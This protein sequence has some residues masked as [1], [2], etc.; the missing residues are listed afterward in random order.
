MKSINLI[1]AIL[2]VVFSACA[3]KTAST[4]LG[5]NPAKSSRGTPSTQGLRSNVRGA[6]SPAGASSVT[7]SASRQTDDDELASGGGTTTSGVRKKPSATNGAA[8]DSLAPG[9]AARQMGGGNASSVT[10][11]ASGSRNKSTA[12]NG[13][14]GDSSAPGGAA[15]Q[16]GVGNA[17]SVTGS[18][19]GSRNKSTATNGVAGD[20]SLRSGAANPSRDDRGVSSQEVGSGKAPAASASS[21]RS[22][23]GS[24]S[25][26]DGAQKIT[27]KFGANGSVI[28]T[29]AAGANAGQWSSLSG[30]RFKVQIGSHSGEMVLLN[31]NTASL[32]MGGSTIELRR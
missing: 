25:G 8:G 10:G 3:S 14:A 32:N 4:D 17:S 5:V 7:R 26:N 21:S 27:V 1:P 24:W 22:V 23:T 29:N 28:L 6:D 19:S 16:T 12:T 15:R 11:S 31:T 18:A 20:S 2:G 13:V 9:G 30:G